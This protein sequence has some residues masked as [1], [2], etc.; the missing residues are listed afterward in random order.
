VLEDVTLG[1]AHLDVTEG[2]DARPWI[3][4]RKSGSFIQRLIVALLVFVAFATCE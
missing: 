4:V 3:R 1:G 2:Q